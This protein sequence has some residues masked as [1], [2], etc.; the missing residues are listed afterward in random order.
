MITESLFRPDV[1]ETIFCTVAFSGL[2]SVMARAIL[3][4][5]Q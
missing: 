3:W 2:A 1:A 5:A 4:C